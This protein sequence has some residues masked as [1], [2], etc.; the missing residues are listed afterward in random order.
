MKNLLL[1]LIIA[2]GSMFFVH[3]AN[4]TQVKIGDF[5]TA[6]ACTTTVDGNAK[7]VGIMPFRCFSGAQFYSTDLVAVIIYN[8]ADSQYCHMMTTASFLPYLLYIREKQITSIYVYPLTT[9]VVCSG[10]TVYGLETTENYN[11]AN[12]LI[13]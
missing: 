9:T 2:V 4:A 7:I 8:N 5:A 10:T 13:K 6:T 12:I 11:Y 1:V 3:E